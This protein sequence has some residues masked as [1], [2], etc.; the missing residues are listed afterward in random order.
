M[1]IEISCGNSHKSGHASKRVV[2]NGSVDV[3]AR[4]PAPRSDHQ[5]GAEASRQRH[6]CC[7]HQHRRRQHQAEQL[8]DKT[9]VSLHIEGSGEHLL[10]FSHGGGR[11]FEL[12][13]KAPQPSRAETLA[14]EAL[15]WTH[16]QPNLQ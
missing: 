14:P 8:R 12:G 7:L 10:H 2:H 5:A 11:A 6:H 3:G 4:D 1:I 9:R 16:L 15:K 13:Q